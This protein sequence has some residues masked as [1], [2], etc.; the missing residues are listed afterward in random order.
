MKALFGREEKEKTESKIGEKGQKGEKI[1]RKSGKTDKRAG[2]G[3]GG[4]ATGAGRKADGVSAGS[5]DRAKGT[6]CENGTPG[7]LRGALRSGNPAKTA[8]AEGTRR[9]GKRKKSACAGGVFRRKSGKKTG[10]MRVS[11]GRMAFSPSRGVTK[12]SRLKFSVKGDKINNS[13]RR[14]TCPDWRKGTADVRRITAVRKR[15]GL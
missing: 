3:T 4:A 14:L 7:M 5:A 1:R 6:D 15:K 11:V 13:K 9:R 8:E 10:R 2:N 12:R